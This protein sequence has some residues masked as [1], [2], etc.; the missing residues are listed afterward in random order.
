MLEGYR[1]F[2]QSVGGD[3]RGIGRLLMLQGKEKGFLLSK[4]NFPP[5][6]SLQG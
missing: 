3:V 2:P 1:Q 6:S 4:H 5:L